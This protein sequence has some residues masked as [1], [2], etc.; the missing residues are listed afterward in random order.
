MSWSGEI[1]ICNAALSLLGATRITSLDL[2]TS[3]NAI[4][5]N[6]FYSQCRDT[7]L[8]AYPW[9]FATKRKNLGAPLAA[10]DADYPVWG[11]QYGYTL[12]TTP[13]CLRVLEVEDLNPYKI[14][15]RLLYSNS[16]SV[17]IKYIARIESPAQFDDGFKVALAA[18]IAMNLAIPITKSKS[19][20]EAMSALYANLMDAA[21]HADTQEG[22]PDEIDSNEL[23]DVR[24][25]SFVSNT[26]AL[27]G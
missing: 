7:A 25:G 20:L 8:R 4:L 15:G 2:D 22:T 21:E 10:I 17:L 5:C 3:T 9:N 14:E 24:N 6:L 16:S 27:I 13:Y 12:P 26:Q 1:E 11:F 19:M 23:L 18:M